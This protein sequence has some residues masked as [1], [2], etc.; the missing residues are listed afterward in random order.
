MVPS[1]LCGVWFAR[2]VH[3]VQ[4]D[5]CRSSSSFVAKHNTFTMSQCVHAVRNALRRLLIGSAT[6][7]FERQ[8]VKDG[9]N[10]CIYR[11]CQEGLP[12]LLPHITRQRLRLPLA[13]FLTLLKARA[14]RIPKDVPYATFQEP[15]ATAAAADGDVNGATVAENGAAAATRDD[16][17]A[18]PAVASRALIDADEVAV[19]TGGT[20]M[21]ATTA[22]ADAG[23]RAAP[24]QEGG[25]AVTVDGQAAPTLE[26]K[27]ACSVLGTVCAGCCVVT[28]LC[29]PVRAARP[30][31][32]GFDGFA[33]P[34]SP[35]ACVRLTRR[36]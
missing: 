14:M 25:F 10:P 32:I 11:I 13:E 22:A 2:A 35:A 36:C 9:S 33:S 30:Q 28:L 26:S 34:A 4:A 3:N 20:S 6:Q 15:T 5:F 18:A 1:K 17:A 12:F 19:A 7:V 24:T 21:E 27:E 31:V 16:S 23:A 8:Q 29:A